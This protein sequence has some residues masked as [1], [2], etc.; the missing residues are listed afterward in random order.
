MYDWFDELDDKTLWDTTTHGPIDSRVAAL[1]VLA[2]RASERNAHAE[3]A[4]LHERIVDLC[5]E[6]NATDDALVAIAR[7]IAA[8]QE[9]EEWENIEALRVKAEAL[10]DSLFDAVAWREFYSA[11]GWAAYLRRAYVVAL[12]FVEKA[13][14]CTEE[15][16]STHYRALHLCQKGVLTAALGRSADGIVFLQE[17][18]SLAREESNLFMVAD[19]LADLSIIQSRTL[20]REAALAPAQEAAALLAEVPPFGPLHFRVKFALG[21]AYLSAG[22][23]QLAFQTFESI[24]ADLPNYLKARTMI[25][26]S[27]CGLDD[28]M[29]ESRAYTV[30]KNSNA[31][32]LVDHIEVTRAMRADPATAIASLTSVIER[33][34]ERDDD[35]TRDE[36]RLVLARKLC[37]AGRHAEAVEQ[38]TILSV[39]NFGDDAYKILTYLILRADAL[40]AVGELVEARSIALAL[41][42]LDRRWE[43]IDAI[44]EG[45]W[46]LATIE[47]AVNGPT[48]EWERLA[49]QCIS[50]LA[51][52]GDFALL[53]ERAEILSGAVVL[54]NQP[55]RGS[56]DT[57]DALI[58]DIANE[59]GSP[60]WTATS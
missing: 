15:S 14:A 23:T 27:E 2:Q 45:Y 21:N 7:A 52:D 51:L 28:E 25:R 1:T 11:Y 53:Q 39:A 42:R 5:M 46:Q 44:A 43:V 8:W 59:T 55:Y 29:W 6:T 34:I 50:L 38:L 30:A 17:G 37:D 22:S 26:M 24:H 60:N 41:S 13:I 35:V 32:D 31:F 40:I 58:A 3:E 9:V 16:G 12:E 57:I 54:D 47:L 49:N 48:I 56:L 18:L 20:D 4:S 10:S 19:I 33:T 36:A